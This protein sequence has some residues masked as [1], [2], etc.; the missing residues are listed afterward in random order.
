MKGDPSLKPGLLAEAHGGVVYVDEI[1]LLP[2]HLADSLLDVA[3][4][5]VMFLEREGFSDLSRMPVSAS[6]QHEPGGRQPAA[7]TSR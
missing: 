6:R 2:D 4:G 3:A 7:P 5:G 1:N